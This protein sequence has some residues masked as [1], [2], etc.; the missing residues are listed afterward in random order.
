MATS[1]NCSTVNGCSST[2]NAVPVEVKTIAKK[3]NRSAWYERTTSLLVS[4]AAAQN[5]DDIARVAWKYHTR[6]TSAAERQG[7]DV[8]PKVC[9]NE[10]V[11]RRGAAV[12]TIY[13]ARIPEA[14]T[15]DVLN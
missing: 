8:A 1:T 15:R 5:N 9:L 3:A 12:R 11:G 13:R 10:L 7:R 6:N 2:A 4:F 14:R